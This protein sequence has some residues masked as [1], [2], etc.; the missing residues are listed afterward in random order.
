MAPLTRKYVGFGQGMGFFRDRLLWRLYP[1]RA[2]WL[3]GGS[4]VRRG[5]DWQGKRNIQ[6]SFETLRSNTGKS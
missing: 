6:T 5:G 2:A 3:S 1:F 4:W